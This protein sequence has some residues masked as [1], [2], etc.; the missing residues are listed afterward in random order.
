M[1]IKL[2]GAV[3][4]VSNGIKCIQDLS[5]ELKQGMNNGGISGMNI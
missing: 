3:K 1:G 2:D 4:W 5:M